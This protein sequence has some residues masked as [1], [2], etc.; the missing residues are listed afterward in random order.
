MVYSQLSA[1]W[2]YTILVDSSGA[3]YLYHYRFGWLGIL[4][5]GVGGMDTTICSRL[6]KQCSPA[7]QPAQIQFI[8]VGTHNT[9]YGKLLDTDI[10]LWSVPD[11][12]GLKRNQNRNY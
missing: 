12:K 7:R 11:T 1:W 5:V 8:A 10:L 2:D 3:G 9:Y 4:Y 6:V